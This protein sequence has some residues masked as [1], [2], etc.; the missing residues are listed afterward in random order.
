MNETQ[1]EPTITTLTP[2]WIRSMA[3]RKV[4]RSRDQGPPARVG[5]KTK[6]LEKGATP[7]PW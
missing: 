5:V 7:A 3:V 6:H 2:P 4:S 1:A